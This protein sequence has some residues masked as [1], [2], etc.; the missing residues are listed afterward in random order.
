MEELLENISIRSMKGMHRLDLPAK[1]QGLWH[2]AGRWW[3]IGRWRSIC[4]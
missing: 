2:G 4:G 3:S 1:L